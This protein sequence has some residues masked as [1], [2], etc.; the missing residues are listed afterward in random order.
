M[1]HKQRTRSSKTK[2]VTQ[3]IPLCPTLCHRGFAL[4]YFSHPTV[5]TFFPIPPTLSSLMVLRLSFHITGYT[6]T[7]MHSVSMSNIKTPDCIWGW[8]RCFPVLR[9]GG[10]GA[11][12]LGG[13]GYTHK[14]ETTHMGEEPSG[15][16]PAPSPH[17]E[18]GKWCVSSTAT[19]ILEMEV[20]GREHRTDRQETMSL[21]SYLVLRFSDVSS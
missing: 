6:F 21:K 18:H 20:T 10:G 9:G 4:L 13:W 14:R 11:G 12:I 15:S 7:Y 19:L 8:N 17:L 16:C 5:Q 1:Y 3:P 2:S